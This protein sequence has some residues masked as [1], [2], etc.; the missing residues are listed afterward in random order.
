LP[1]SAI[2]KQ[3][4]GA[5]SG[6]GLKDEACGFGW[7]VNLLPHMAH[8]LAICAF[9]SST[10]NSMNPRE[11]VIERRILGEALVSG[12]GSVNDWMNR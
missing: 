12:M 6:D 1:K 9:W 3:K 5:D 7:R 11:V 2:A 10:T 4:E 8:C